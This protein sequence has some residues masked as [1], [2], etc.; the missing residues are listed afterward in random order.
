[1]PGWTQEATRTRQ[2]VRVTTIDD[3]HPHLPARAQRANLTDRV[4][5]RDDDRVGP[6]LVNRASDCWRVDAEEGSSI[7]P[8]PPRAGTEHSMVVPIGQR[9]IPFEW[10]LEPGTLLDG[11]GLGG[12]QD[13]K[14]DLGTPG[15]DVAE[16]R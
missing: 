15:G 4:P 5:P 3:R 14:I 12:V 16:P 1:R 6:G 2:Q 7:E 10:P 9:H 11:C 13:R 8:S